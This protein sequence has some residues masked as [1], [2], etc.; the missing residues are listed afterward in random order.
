M[1]VDLGIPTA[2]PCQGSG[3]EVMI[4]GNSVLRQAGDTCEACQLLVRE[5]LVRAFEEGR[6]GQPEDQSSDE[7]DTDGLLATLQDLQ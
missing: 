1:M 6:G 5:C 4:C 7:P 2:P 3:V